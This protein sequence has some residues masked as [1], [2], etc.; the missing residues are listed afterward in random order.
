MQSKGKA[1]MPP[2]IMQ[3]AKETD[4]YYMPAEQHAQQAEQLING[5]LQARGKK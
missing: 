4:K 3:K 5:E 1:P 2:E